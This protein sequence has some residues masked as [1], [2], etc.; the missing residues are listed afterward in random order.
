[1]SVVERARELDDEIRDRLKSV[2]L[3]GELID[4]DRLRRDT[5]EN[6]YGQGYDPCTVSPHLLAVTV[7]EVANRRSDGKTVWPHVFGELRK[8][9]SDRIDDVVLEGR[10]G[11]AF[12]QV[13]RNNGLPTFS[14]LVDQGAHRFVAP[15][16]A[17]AIIPRSLVAV[18]LDRV[19]A[20]ALDGGLVSGIAVYDLEQ[21]FG[22][23]NSG[24]PRTVERFL[25]HGGAVTRDLVERL[26][27]YVANECEIPFGLPPWLRHEV[28]EWWE[29]R[30]AAA[31]PPADS[32][33]R[34]ILLPSP[35][36]QY[37]P[38]SGTINVAL[39]YLETSGRAWVITA[40]SARSRY[41]ANEPLWRRDGARR[42]VVIERP[43]SALRVDLVDEKS[44][45]TARGW[46]LAGI[47]HERPVLFFGSPGGRAL[48]SQD[49]ILGDRWYI[50]RPRGS[51]YGAPQGGTIRTLARLGSPQGWDGFEVDEVEVSGVAT[52]VVGSVT[53]RIA[54]EVPAARIEARNL[55]DY[56]KALDADVLASAGALPVV[57]LPAD[58]ETRLDLWTVK[59]ENDFGKTR[60]STAR[61]LGAVL[62][63]VEW[64]VPLTDLLPE[65]S[66]TWDITVTGR[67]GEGTAA[68][69]ALL[70][71]DWE[72]PEPPIVPAFRGR[73][74]PVVL[75]TAAAVQALEPDDRATRMESGEWLLIDES[76]NG[77]IPLQIDG[78]SGTAMR[79]L[80]KL[81]TISWR[82][83]VD[84]VPTK[85][86]KPRAFTVEDL[87][88]AELTVESDVEVEL[89]VRLV[90]QASG[91]QL[92]EAAPAGNVRRWR[93]PA[94]AFSTTATATTGAATFELRAARP[95]TDPPVRARVGAVVRPAGVT[96]M[97]V[98]PREDNAF[99][100]SWQQGSPVDVTVK[101][102]DLNRPWDQPAEDDMVT[103]TD[104]VYRSIFWAQPGAYTIELW[105]DDGWSGPA[106]IHRAEL[107]VGHDEAPRRHLLSLP[108]TVL[109]LLERSLVESA[110]KDRCLHLAGIRS[111]LADD[112]GGHQLTTLLEA[113]ADTIRY[114]VSAR[115]AS[116]P[117]WELSDALSLRDFDPSVLLDALAMPG[118]ATHLP[119]MLTSLSIGRW[120][121][122]WKRRAR[123]SADTRRALWHTWAPLGAMFD[124]ADPSEE[125][126][127]RVFHHLDLDRKRKLGPVDWV[128]HVGF[129]AHE[130]VQEVRAQRVVPNGNESSH[131]RSSIGAYAV[132]V[133]RLDRQADPVV[134]PPF[135]HVT[136]VLKKQGLWDAGGLRCAPSAAPIESLAAASITLAC[137]DR[138]IARGL[139]V[140]TA[141]QPTAKLSA[142]VA[143]LVPNL[144]AR[145]LCLAEAI[146]K[147][148]YERTP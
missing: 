8:Y 29:A 22:R 9:A 96:G 119:E 6:L 92:Q 103:R 28:D 43:P 18:L 143:H 7:V 34:T 4:D 69:V 51:D 15:I 49:V 140:D 141:S 91:E 44:G 135:D 20:P 130:V 138:V 115:V 42:V 101:L 81:P 23:T 13:V 90:D 84:Q 116:V 66:G 146:L 108:R 37:D 137:W 53:A 78:D 38:G 17:H 54:T 12:E 76:G 1:M 39:P 122:P 5:V 105:S 63:G 142:Q 85:W 139:S 114:G 40:D 36:L 98:E 110:G 80:L 126:A 102:Y 32:G 2:Q 70:P 31:R 145:D 41:L 100:F 118:D 64:L 26:I 65:A 73:K 14:Q 133:L 33:S 47:P 131:A 86:G 59:C 128:G 67:L 68:R 95:G 71:A 136:V 113:L 52:V 35:T 93:F 104:G 25:T 75:S 111:M 56:L 148:I 147:D 127:D 121:S 72:M 112:P 19:I 11:Q 97:R 61:Q 99:E 45:A 144:Y 129:S 82:W 88:T 89:V 50:V 16:L 106:R 55:P 10:I 74:R 120:R 60:T 134:C 58:S 125:A 109:G 124:V 79:V 30:G 24:L 57:R 3:L 87:G 132:D 123:V 83:E 48:A 46:A 27:L 117:W 107:R 77:R 21:R 94:R 62:D